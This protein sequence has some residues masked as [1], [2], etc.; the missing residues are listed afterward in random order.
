MINLETEVYTSIFDDKRKELHYK[1]YVADVYY[2]EDDNHWR[3]S[4]LHVNN[5]TLIAGNTLQEIVKDFES[6]VDTHINNLIN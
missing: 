3:G 2:Y 6:R 1:G 4:V 5:L